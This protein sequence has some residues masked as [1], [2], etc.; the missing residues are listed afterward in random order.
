MQLRLLAFCLPVLLWGCAPDD[1][2]DDDD[3][4]DGGAETD[5][6]ADGGSD[7]GADQRVGPDYSLGTC[8]D[9]DDGVI[10]DFATGD[11]DYRVKIVLPPDPVGAPV[12]FAWHWLG[13]SSGD[14]VRTMDLDDLAEDEGVIIIAPD[15]DGSAYEWHFLDGPDGNP[16]LLLFEDLLSCI[17]QQYDVDLDRIYSLGMSA[18]GLMTTY[19]TMHEAQWLAATAPFSGGT[20]DGFYDTPERPLPILLTWGGASDTYS[21]LSFDDTSQ[22]FSSNVQA[23]GSFVVEC[24]HSGGHTI[25]NGATDYAWEFFVDHPMGVD[26]EPYAQA[27]PGDFPSWCSLP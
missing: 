2:G 16:D 18:G 6:G 27:L 14:I 5:G 25:P 13:G 15:S 24:V 22:H 3:A 12:I 9:L 7:G 1:G 21:T 26:P 4:G 17:W 19:V 11:T 23:D 8:P 20:I 10:S